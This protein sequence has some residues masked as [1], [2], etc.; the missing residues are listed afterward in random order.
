MQQL[1]SLYPGALGALE[2]QAWVF[3]RMTTERL[4][5]LLAMSPKLAKPA[6]C[7][8]TGL[9]LI[10]QKSQAEREALAKSGLGSLSRDLANRPPPPRRSRRSNSPEHL[11]A[12]E[13]AY[14]SVI[15]PTSKRII[16]AV[17]RC[18]FAGSTVIS[19]H[20]KGEGT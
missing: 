12:A 18:R 11:L 5:M 8:M 13:L 17:L 2:H 20:M 16:L 10:R 1:H 19:N 15:K 9:A 6:D 7:A 14:A 4:L 3:S